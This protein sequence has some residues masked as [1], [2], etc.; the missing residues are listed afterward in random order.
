M[1]VRMTKG[2]S[3]TLTYVTL[4]DVELAFSYETVVAYRDD[5]GWWKSE[6]VWSQTTGRHLAEIPGNKIPHDEFVRRLEAVVR[7]WTLETTPAYGL[8]KM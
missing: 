3:Q 7:S 8:D 4:G 5:A 2:S 1:Q 6:N